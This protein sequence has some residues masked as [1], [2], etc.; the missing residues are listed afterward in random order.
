MSTSIFGSADPLAEYLV[1]L[2]NTERIGDLEA[3]PS[4]EYRFRGLAER[5]TAL[6]GHHETRLDEITAAV[7]AHPE[8]TPWEI[9]RSVT[10]SRPFS[11]LS[12][13]LAYM[14]LRETN[15]H[16]IVLGERGVLTSTPGPPVRWSPAVAPN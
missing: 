11:D 6:L 1:S 16:L 10:W 7:H 2:A 9:T 8:S 3:L 12:E 4:H 15:A 14:A 13:G 5:V